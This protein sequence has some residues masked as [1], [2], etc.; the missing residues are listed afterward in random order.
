MTQSHDWIR[1]L[2][3]AELHLHLE[4]TLEPEMVFGLAARNG[5]ALPYASVEQLRAAYRFT[6]L[7]DFLAVYYQGMSVLLTEQDFHELTLAYMRRA[8]A[9]GVRHAEVFF[10]PQAHLRRGVPMQVVMRGIGAGL[11]EAQ[12]AMGISSCL[13]LCFLRDLSE[14]DALETL[15]LAE[16]YLGEIT[17]VGLDSAEL[18]HPPAKFE[19]VF[20]A[21]RA[22]GLR[23]VAHA[24][25]E[26][27]PAYVREALDLLCIDRLDHGNRAMEDPELVERLRATG[28]TLT[29]CPLSNLRLGGVP[30]MASHP[31]R[32]MLE[33][34]LR[35]TVNS[36][37][38]AYFGGYVHENFVQAVEHLALAPAQV[39]ALA[40]NSFE[41][42]FLPQHQI[43]A[44][45]LDV[46]RAAIAAGLPP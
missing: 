26:G 5:V 14:S 28:M 34:G 21:A 16:P 4:G 15:R 7:D 30:H 41:G 8:D 33:A 43:D 22:R 11:R 46:D 32:R 27:P 1:S 23:L 39:V 2:P 45:L 17:A 42:S 18:Q 3:K 24:G 36:D 20:A 12:D 31:L 9:D 35:V 40:R 10:D 25:E 19:R 38:P 29:V 37:D 6:Q 44:H 13:I